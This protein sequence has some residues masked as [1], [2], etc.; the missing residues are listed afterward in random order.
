[1]ASFGERVVGAM[2]LNAGTFQEVEHDPTAMGQAMGVIVLAAVASGVGAIWFTGI[3]G[4]VLGVLQALVG[5]LIW[6]AVVWLVG[7]KV[8][9]EPTTKADF[10]ETFRVLGFAAAPGL[11]SIIGVIPILGWFLAVLI[12]LVVLIWTIAAM[13]IAVRE[14]L[15]YSSTGKAAIVVII[16]A[17][18]YLVIRAILSGPR[19]NY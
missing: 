4:L 2:K 7:T 11:L 1:M 18:C 9:P 13:V 8:M 19:L 16:G 14:V 6:A 12:G 17:I 5:Y 15:D 10:P 3:S